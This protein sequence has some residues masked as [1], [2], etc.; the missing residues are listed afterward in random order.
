MTIH[1][2]YYGM[3]TCRPMDMIAQDQRDVLLLITYY[4]PF[5]EVDRFW[6]EIDYWSIKM[7]LGYER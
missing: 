3:T 5:S 2:W 4:L 1:A 7:V 6:G